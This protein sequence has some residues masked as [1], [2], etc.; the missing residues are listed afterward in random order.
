MTKRLLKTGIVGFDE[1]LEGGLIP[2][3][4]YL[5]RGGPGTGKTTLGIHFLV[6]GLKSDEKLLFVSMTEDVEKIKQNGKKYGFPMDKITFLD[7]SPK[8]DFIAN[9]MDYDLFSSSEMEQEPI[10]EKL[11]N[12]IDNIKPDRIFFDGFTQLKYLTSDDFKFRKQILSFIQFVKKYNSTIL[13][14]SEVGTTINDDDLQFMVDGI[15]NLTYHDQQ[16]SLEISKY[17]GSDFNKGDHSMKFNNKGIEVYPQLKV[18]NY[19]TPPGKNKIDSGIFEIDKMLSGGIQEGTITLITGQ[20]GVGKTT[21]GTQFIKNSAEKGK[22][23][24]IY[25]FE[26]SHKA[27]IDRCKA[28]NIPLE[29]MIANNNLL[30]KTI[31]PLEYH[32]DEF[33]YKVKSD[34]EQ[35]GTSIVLIDSISSY[36]LTFKTENNANNMVRKLHALFDYLKS[37]GITVF[38]TNEI[39]NITGEFSIT[40]TDTSYLA[41]NVLFLR[42]L[43][44]NGKLE[45]AI[46]ILKM[47]MSDFENTMRRYRITSEGIK[48]GAPLDN[49]RGILTG[50]P[51][52]FDERPEKK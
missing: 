23:A 47:R 43:E 32:P 3:R 30:V 34:I 46:G 41:D 6:E 10:I 18:S 25:T 49:M 36:F 44:M 11:T 21:L 31:S 27:L 19:D 42:Y 9:N 48:V 29:K 39:K 14:T 13:L 7:L 24:I 4:F 40:S 50:N 33:S 51:E 52:I 8:S 2:S 28:I 26:E 35:Q 15:I 1:I 20:S 16:H 37:Q 5:V 45:K 17:R 22:K 12:T 38:M